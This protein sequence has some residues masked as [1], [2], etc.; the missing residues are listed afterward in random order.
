[1]SEETKD[2]TPRE[3][4]VAVVTYPVKDGKP[5]GE[6]TTEIKIPHPA[7]DRK[8]VTDIRVAEKLIRTNTGAKKRKIDFDLSF[9]KV[10]ALM[11]A[12]KC[13]FTGVLLNDVENDPSKFTIDRLDNDRGYVDDN[14]VAASLRINKIKADATVDEIVS[15]YNALK[16]RNL[17]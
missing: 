16:K 4:I 9:S 1:M 10:K 8:K 6:S 3:N 11:K 7:F 13:F 5:T 2:K 17:V 12:K 14:V 15:L